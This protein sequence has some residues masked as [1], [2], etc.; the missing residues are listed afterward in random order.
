[1]P[2]YASG[3]TTGLVC[4]I[5]DGLT[6]TTPVYEGCLIPHAINETEIAG[7][8]VTIYM[9]KLLQSQGVDLISSAEMEIAR[10]VKE[11][12]TYVASDYDKEFAQASS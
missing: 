4:E 6:H 12:I 5:G 9:Q 11:K 10:D 2:L 3:R 7:R 8:F 1:M